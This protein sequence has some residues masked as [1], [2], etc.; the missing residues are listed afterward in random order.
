MDNAAAYDTVAQRGQSTTRIS[1]AIKA[2][3]TQE[4]EQDRVAPSPVEFGHHQGKLSPITTKVAATN[5]DSID[6]RRNG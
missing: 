6:D 2:A 5:F 4:N 3:K 1:E